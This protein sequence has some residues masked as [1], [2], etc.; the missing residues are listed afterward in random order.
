MGFSVH[1]ASGDNEHVYF[2]LKETYHGLYF[3]FQSLTINYHVFTLCLEHIHGGLSVGV[4]LALWWGMARGELGKLGVA[5]SSRNDNKDARSME[6]GLYG[7]LYSPG[8]G[9]D[10]APTAARPHPRNT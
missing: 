8:S 10:I 1:V 9:H 6:I 4:A 5:P 7:E 3:S 2:L